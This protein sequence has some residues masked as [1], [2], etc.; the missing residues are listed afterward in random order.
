M[1]GLAAAIFLTLAI[2][3]TAEAALSKVL[4]WGSPGAGDGQFQGAEG[5]AVDASGFVYVADPFNRRVQKFTPDGVFVT[6]WGSAGG[7][8][9]QFGRPFDVVVDH[10]GDILVSDAFSCRVQKFTNTGVYLGQWGTEGSGD[11]Q[12]GQTSYLA[13]DASGNVLAQDAVYSRVQRFTSAGAFAGLWPTNVPDEGDIFGNE[14][15]V[16]PTGNVVVADYPNNRIVTFSASGTYLGQW[17]ST[18]TGDGQLT[19]PGHVAVDPAGNVFVSDGNNLRLEKFSPTGVYLDQ[20]TE[21]NNSY[22][23]RGIAFAPGGIVYVAADEGRVIKLADTAVGVSPPGAETAA[24]T[25]RPNPV[26]LEARFSFTLP[27][28]ADVRLE[29]FDAAGRS[30]SRAWAGALD[31]GPQSVRWASAGLPGGVY[32]A[33]LSAGARH[34]TKRFVHL[35]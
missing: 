18:G 31:A 24:I 11:G 7:G 13:V 15:A 28:R 25:V 5:I 16:T 8:D 4:E 10:A 19:T 2:A 32:F 35:P 29:V 26:A 9:G 27:A 14:L 30:V 33:R 12:F 20:W 1:K 34:E 17:G 21:P 3:S 22:Y 23:P 6:K